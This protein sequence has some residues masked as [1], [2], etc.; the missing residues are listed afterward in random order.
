MNNYF[1]INMASK[2]GNPQY[3]PYQIST[4][5]QLKLLKKKKKEKKRASF[6][7]FAKAFDIVN[8]KILLKSLE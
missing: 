1:N 4:K 3:M 5:T 2:K 6:L 7:D 8:H